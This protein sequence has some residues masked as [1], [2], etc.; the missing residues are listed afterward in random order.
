M[1]PVELRLGSITGIWKSRPDWSQFRQYLETM[2]PEGDDSQGTPMKL[3]RYAYFLEL[4]VNL[5][6]QEKHLREEVI[7]DDQAVNQKLKEMVM[8][9]KTDP[10]DFFGTERCLKCVHSGVRKEILD[11]V[12]KVRK[13]Q[14]QAGA[15]VYQPAYSPVLDKLNTLVGSYNEVRQIESLRNIQ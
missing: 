1:E 14:M 9:I 12:K 6:E 3:S 15:W 11:N 4:Y 10:E 7:D 5:Y 8:N 2:E 13:D